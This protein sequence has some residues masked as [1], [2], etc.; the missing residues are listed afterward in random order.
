MSLF[1][2]YTR[3]YAVDENEQK[4]VLGSLLFL[5]IPIRGG[6]SFINFVLRDFKK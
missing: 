1:N 5:R 4:K 6:Q 3:Y 2:T